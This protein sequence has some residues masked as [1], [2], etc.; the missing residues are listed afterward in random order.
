MDH[1]EC[2]PGLGDY[3]SELL[4]L[5][6]RKNRLSENKEDIVWLLTVYLGDT[7]FF[8]LD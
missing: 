6:V 1:Y 7:G 3:L 2:V 8:I 4:D 5:T